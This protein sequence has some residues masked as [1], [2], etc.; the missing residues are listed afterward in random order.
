MIKKEFTGFSFLYMK[1][2]PNLFLSPIV[3]GNPH[4]SGNALDFGP[5]PSSK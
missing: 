5:K 4:Q 3:L 1:M 2:L